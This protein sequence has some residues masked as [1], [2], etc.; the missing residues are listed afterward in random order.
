M[1]PLDHKLLRDLW[2]M[3]GQAIAIGA[4]IAMGVLM[5]VMMTGLVASLTE[6]RDAY[7][8]RYRLADVF[9]PVARAPERLAAQLAEIPSVSSV[10]TRVVGRALIDL[11]TQVLPVQAQAVSLPDR[12]PPALNDVFLTDGRMPASG[13]ADEVLLLNSFAAEHDLRPG[14]TLR[15]TMNGSRRS[16]DI[17]GLAQSP[18][19]LYTTAPGELVPDDARFGVI[20]MVR[21][22]LSAAYDMEGAFNEV[23]L[24]LARGSSEEALLDAVDRALESYGGT[25]AYGLADQLSNA[26]VTQ[27]IEGL[28]ASTVGVPPIFLAVAAFLLYIVI[29]RV[30]QAEREE[31]GLMKAFGYTDIEVGTHYFKLILAIAAGGALAGCLGGIAA[32]R[33]LIGLYTEYFKFPFLVFQL[34]PASFAIG[35]TVSILSASAGG[36]FVLRRVF[37]L[38]PAVAMR[39]PAPPN[40]SRTGRIGQSFSQLLDQPSRMVLRRL[41][42][43]PGRMAGSII[44]IASGMALS[45][46]MLTIYAGFDRSIDQTFSIVDR[47]DVMVSFTHAVSDK[48][49]FELVRLPGVERAEPVRNVSVVLRNGLESHRGGLIGLPPAPELN[50]ALDDTLAPIELPDRGVVLSDVLAEILDISPGDTLIAEVREGRQPR[51]EIP[52]A[53]TAQT[54]LGSPAYMSL[55]ALNRAMREPGRISGAYLTIDEAE[56]EAIYAALQDMPTVAGLS[57]KSQARDAFLRMLNEGAGAIRYAMGVIAFVITFGIVYNAA[58]IALA[59][60]ARDLASLRVIGFTKGEAAFVLLGEL[61]VVTLVALPV[62]AGL[63]YYLSFVIAAGFSTELYQIPAVFDPTTYGQA[64]LV[65]LG[66]ALVSG[67]LVK[68][69][70][71]RSDLIEALKTRD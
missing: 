62:G 31:I 19:F 24:G 1:S 12:G 5:L 41:T 6:T 14:D 69:D 64:M 9:A 30:V 68:R 21:S 35:I 18:E 23:L 67:W 50:R 58:R 7:Y 70:L 17:V 45:A 55:D 40:F 33:G 44:G 29:S 2:R 42:R 32:G 71:D 52:V 26:F 28:E 59:E 22:G 57:V 39:A 34:D 27:E 13:R 16:F 10:Q 61:A 56:A 20:W 54:L 25:G 38:T 8:D 65:V 60:R 66:A 51:L 37:A 36:I 3:K 15:A 11:P 47:S 53:A 48:T 4:V 43:Q 63:G 49:L 46:A